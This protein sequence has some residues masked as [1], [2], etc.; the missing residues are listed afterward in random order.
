MARIPSPREAIPYLFIVVSSAEAPFA[1]FLCAQSDFSQMDTLGEKR[2]VMYLLDGADP[3]DAMH[4][5]RKCVGF[6][7]WAWDV[8]GL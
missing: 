6:V 8:Q 5:R 7:S 2:W 1:T 3:C 4:N